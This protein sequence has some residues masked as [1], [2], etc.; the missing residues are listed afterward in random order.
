MTAEDF[1]L[2]AAEAGN[3]K[4]AKALPLY[5]PGFPKVSF[6]GAVSV[7]IVPDG[8]V[9]NPMPSEGTIRTV[10]AYLNQRRLLTT[11]L[12]VIPPTYRLVEIRGDVIAEQSADIA[13]VKQAIEDSLLLYLHPLK[14]GENNK[15][16]P[17][18]GPIFFSRVYQRVLSVNGVRNV[19]SL[20]IVLDGQAKDACQDATINPAELVYSTQHAN[21]SVN[22]PS[23]N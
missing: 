19:V 1:E 18:G 21:I 9:P 23:D 8:T 7:V 11:E 13:Q 22:Y 12:Y 10:C 14:G 5:N 15:G 4:R 17:F 6:P 3:V 2:L 20:Q 16:W